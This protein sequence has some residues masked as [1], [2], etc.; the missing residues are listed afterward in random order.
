METIIRGFFPGVKRFLETST[1]F[2]RNSPNNSELLS[3]FWKNIA[4]KESHY[5]KLPPA[6]AGFIAGACGKG[7]VPAAA[8][9]WFKA[10]GFQESSLPCTRFEQ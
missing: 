4:E 9:L 7:M 2:A 3:G 5:S 6:D 10:Q 8:T 1:D